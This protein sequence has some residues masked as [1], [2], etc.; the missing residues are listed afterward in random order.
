M[1]KGKLLN[2]VALLAA[3]FVA[4]GCVADDDGNN[5]LPAEPQYGTMQFGEEQVPVNLVVAED[6]GWFQMVVMSP[7]TDKLHLTTS[8]IIGVQ[9]D[10]LGREINVARAS[11]NYDYVV[12][13]E[14]P[15]CYYA[16]YR[17]LQS[18]TIFMSRQDNRFRV[19]V[20]VVLYDGTPFRYEN[21]NILL[22]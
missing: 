13:Y 17:P 11:H 21:D 19:K 2:M 12:V 1:L 18:G 7:L 9:H 15:L 10:L 6:N 20:D 5:Q 16:P 14:D 4:V 3:M 8:A 22:E